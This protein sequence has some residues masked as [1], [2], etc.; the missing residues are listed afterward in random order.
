MATAVVVPQPTTQTVTPGFLVEQLKVFAA[1]VKKSTG[2]ELA[3]TGIMTKVHNATVTLKEKGADYATARASLYGVFKTHGRVLKHFQKQFGFA[4]LDDVYQALADA[5]ARHLGDVRQ[6]GPFHVR[7][8]QIQVSG[9]NGSTVAAASSGGNYAFQNEATSA[10]RP[11]TAP[12]PVVAAAPAVPAAPSADILA[13]LPFVDLTKPEA[14]AAVAAAM[15]AGGVG[16]TS[17]GASSSSAA[18]VAAVQTAQTTPVAASAVVVSNNNKTIPEPNDELQYDDLFIL[19]KNV[20]VNTRANPLFA[21]K[22]LGDN[23]TFEAVHDT[24]WAA[25]GTIN[26]ARTALSLSDDNNVARWKK[27]DGQPHKSV[28]KKGVSASIYF[29]WNKKA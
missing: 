8:D 27:N 21:G 12:A 25:Y 29:G 18:P 15:K 5:H 11:A 13:L 28:T 10:P 23:P 14:A 24:I 2:G 17:S 19:Y 26:E 3:T 1:D 6:A 4:T 9:Q 20:P 7:L 22:D 16:S